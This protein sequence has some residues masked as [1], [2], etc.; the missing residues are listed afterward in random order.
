MSLSFGGTSEGEMASNSWRAFCACAL[1]QGACL[2]G[3]D[4][5][6]HDASADLDEPDTAPDP[7]A[8]DVGPE[9]PY[10][11]GDCDPSDSGADLV[12]AAPCSIS[13]NGDGTWT[14]TCADGRALRVGPGLDLSGQDLRVA[15][16]DELDLSGADLTGADLSES[17]LRGAKLVDAKLADANLFKTVLVGADLRGADLTG[18]NFLGTYVASVDFRGAKLTDADLTALG[19]WSGVRLD[20]ADLRGATFPGIWVSPELQGANLDGANLHMTSFARENSKEPIPNF[21]HASLRGADLRSTGLQEADLTEADLTDARL[22]GADLS[23]ADLSGSELAGANLTGAKLSGVRARDLVNCPA[24]LPSSGWRCVPQRDTGHALLGPGVV[25]E[26]VDLTGADL[27]GTEL[28][29]AKIALLGCPAKL[30]S[31]AWK[32][33]AVSGGFVLAGRGIDLAGKQL[34]GAALSGAILRDANL[35]G[36]NLLNADLTGADLTDADL[37]DAMIGTLQGCPAALPDTDWQCL[38]EQQTNRLLAPPSRPFS[39]GNSW[40]LRS[41]LVQ[42][43][44]LSGE[45]FG[46][47]TLNPSLDYLDL[48][49]MNFEG[50][51]LIFADIEGVGLRDTNLRDADLTHAKLN[52]VDLRGADLSGAHMYLASFVDTSA[53]DLVG[54]PATLPKSYWRCLEQ[55]SGRYLLAG[56]G[57]S[58]R[59]ADLRDIELLDDSPYELLDI[60]R[61]CSTDQ[62]SMDESACIALLEG[63]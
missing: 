60:L 33:V 18:A 24:L 9:C 45:N 57:V 42:G 26:G 36:A 12:P 38:T 5:P 30:P 6:D 8:P 37:T 25:L 29:G 20:G 22:A 3:A 13:E 14:A 15:D 53:F 56:P 2:D 39:D 52:F 61:L 44:D 47:M 34:G 48:R 35:T 28:W 10:T 50:A 21:R 58:F 19:N 7:D 27:E 49:E 43:A 46:G 41:K 59:S 55:R 62:E 16:L 51:S 4:A 17:N 23:G 40:E 32:C 1:L 63:H 31:S 11:G 54:C